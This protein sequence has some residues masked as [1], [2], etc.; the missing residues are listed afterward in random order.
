MPTAP[1]K[2]L[3]VQRIQ[4]GNLVFVTRLVAKKKADPIIRELWD[5]TSRLPCLLE[6]FTEGALCVDLME[7]DDLNLDPFTIDPKS[8]DWY[9]YT[10]LDL[11]RPITT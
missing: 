11:D 8:A 4:G 1:A 10:F 7:G 3:L 2:E 6:D 9:L 5:H